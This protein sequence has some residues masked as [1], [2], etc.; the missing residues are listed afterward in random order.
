[1]QHPIIG[2]R[3]TYTPDGVE[4]EVVHLVQDEPLIVEGRSRG[5]VTVFVRV[6]YHPALNRCA[7]VD[8]TQPLMSV[9][10]AQ[11]RTGHT[12]RRAGTSRYTQARP[13]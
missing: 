2:V 4:D 6:L 1:M 11:R 3:F 9:G 12:K 5:A 8:Y 13:A 7:L 10:Y